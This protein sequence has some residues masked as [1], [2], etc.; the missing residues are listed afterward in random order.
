[1]NQREL[2]EI[3]SRF[4]DGDKKY[5]KCTVFLEDEYIEITDNDFKLVN[6]VLEE[7]LLNEI[8]DNNETLLSGSYLE[9]FGKCFECKEEY[10]YLSE[11]IFKIV[12]DCKNFECIIL[13]NGD[14]LYGAVNCYKR[15]SGRSGN[16]LSHEDLEKSYLIKV[17]NQEIIIEKELEKTAVLA[18]NQTHYIEYKDKKIYSTSKENDNSI[19][20]CDDI[21]WDKGPT[22]YN[23]FEVY[24]VDDIFIIYGNKATFFS[25]HITLIVGDIS[26]SNIETLINDEETKY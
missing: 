2:G 15:S 18:V 22:F 8:D 19:K 20:V 3:I 12:G 16:L 21:W 1:M 24:F 17:E 26:G 23:C 7:D 13:K 25:E 14:E 4:T 5:L 9:Y 11:K 10:E 6:D